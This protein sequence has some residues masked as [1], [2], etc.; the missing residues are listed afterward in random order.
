MARSFRNVKDPY[1]DDYSF[2]K[3]ESIAK[4]RRQEKLRL[5][6]LS[7]PSEETDDIQVLVHGH[8]AEAHLTSLLKEN[9]Y[10]PY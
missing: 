7:M 5:G 10:R 1:A 2:Q 6:R 9:S 8:E 4:M 3:K